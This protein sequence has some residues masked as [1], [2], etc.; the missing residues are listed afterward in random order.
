MLTE[1]LERRPTD[2]R[3]LVRRKDRG[4]TQRAPEASR[5]GESGETEKRGVRK[6]SERL[7]VFGFRFSGRVSGEAAVCLTAREVGW[8]FVPSVLY[9]IG[10]ITKAG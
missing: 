10:P 5:D 8:A 6:R 9:W 1:E 4:W 3:A 7:Y 2:G